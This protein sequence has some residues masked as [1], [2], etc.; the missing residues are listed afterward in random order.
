MF[1]YTLASY[2]KPA[3]CIFKLHSSLE[4]NFTFSYAYVCGKLR[5]M[6]VHYCSIIM[7]VKWQH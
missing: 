5:Y 3:T 6:F 2:V 7:Y 4:L 1:M